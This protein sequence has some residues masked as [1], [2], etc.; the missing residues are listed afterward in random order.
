MRTESNSIQNPEKHSGI[1]F[2]RKKTVM[3]TKLN[4]FQA[5]PRVDFSFEKKK[6]RKRKKEKKVHPR[7]TN[8][9]RWAA[10]DFIGQ[11]P[12][13]PKKK[14]PQKKPQTTNEKRGNGGDEGNEWGGSD[15]TVACLWKLIGA[16]N[17]TAH[18]TS[19]AR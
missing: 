18:A 12:G 7:P 5:N 6:E 11:A 4:S 16:P 14:I 3:E 15:P 10:V 9:A 17:Q 2:K 13:R 8:G 1:E 19:A